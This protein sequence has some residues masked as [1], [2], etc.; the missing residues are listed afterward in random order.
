MKRFLFFLTAFAM[1]MAMALALAGCTR[2]PLAV[3]GGGPGDG[4]FVDA[5]F[6][7]VLGPR[8]KAFADGTQA[9]K[10][11][12][13]LYEMGANSSFTYVT[14]TATP[15]DI[16]SLKATVTFNGKVHRGNDYRMVFWAQAEGAPY[17]I[18]W[19][20]AA[21]TGPTV[22]VTSYTGNS[23]LAND[24]ARDAFEALSQ[25]LRHDVGTELDKHR[26]VIQQ[27]IELDIIA[28]Y[29]YQ[30]GSVEA[31]LNYDKQLLEAERLLKSSEEYNAILEGNNN[32]GPNN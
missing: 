14:H 27:M 20:T 31:G 21:T 32:K 9:V 11:Y 25:S 29:Y 13:G 23:N 1:A 8:T 16:S 5:T 28:A 22:T 6:A 10:L 12:A 4:G 17:S 18:D 7:V 19:A 3:P 15:I 2:E 30:R 26:E 24:E